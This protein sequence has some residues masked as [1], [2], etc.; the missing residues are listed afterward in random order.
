MKKQVLLIE[1]D[2]AM[3]TSLAQTLDLEGI[4][5][6]LANGLAQARRTIRSN[7]SGVVLSD[8]RMP[9]HD[10]FDVLAHVKSIDSDMPVVMLT[11][12]A[13]VPMALRAMKNGAYDFL[14]KPCPSDKLLEVIERALAYRNVV[15][16]KRKLEREAQRNDIVAQSFPGQSDTTKALQSSL[17]RIGP[18]QSNVFISGEKGAGKKLAAFTIHKLSSEQAQFVG[19]NFASQS[20]PLSDLHVP[21]GVVSLSIKSVH[22]A[23]PADLEVLFS[24]NAQ[25]PDIRFLLSSTTPLVELQKTDAFAHLL[26]TLAPEQISVPS[27]RAR[28][29]DLPVMFE[30]ILR[31]TVRDL[32]LDMPEVPETVYARILTKDWSGNLPEMREYARTY[33]L[34]TGLASSDIETKPLADQLYDFEALVLREALRRTNGKAAM[35]A[36]QL[37]LP[38]KTFYDRLARYDI[39]PKEFRQH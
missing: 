12:E 28:R 1:D 6:V 21:D 30:Q 36:E 31:Q 16:Q 19:H 27:L 11:G 34:E 38:R 7:F 22:L 10:G 33:V 32:D 25:R 9:Q 2:D 3:R 26:E 8:I 20:K 29:K 35:A 37:G 24:L 23:T 39:K 18:S 5:V 13:D 4:T 17:R 15:L 14:E